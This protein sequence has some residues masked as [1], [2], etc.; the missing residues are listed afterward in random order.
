MQ[1]TE[2]MEIHNDIF[3]TNIESVYKYSVS[4]FLVLLTLSTSVSAQNMESSVAK[5]NAAR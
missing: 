5:I 4:I 1:C 2:E 3:N